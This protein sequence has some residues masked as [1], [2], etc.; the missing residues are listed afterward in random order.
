M[1]VT[2]FISSIKSKFFETN[3]KEIT[4]SSILNYEPDLEAGEGYYYQILRTT[5]ELKDALELKDTL[6]LKAPPVEFVSNTQIYDLE[7]G[8]KSI[9]SEKNII[10]EYDFTNNISF[11][12][13]INYFMALTEK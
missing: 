9:I 5:L 4:T 7:M 13:L 8:D 2:T 12:N 11:L 6:E 3:R 1:S 10:E